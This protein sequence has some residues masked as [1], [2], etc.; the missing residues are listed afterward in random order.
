MAGAW[1]REQVPRAYRDLVRS[2]TPQVKR[3]LGTAL[4]EG[5]KWG[6]EEEAQRC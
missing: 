6:W 1:L 5:W 2:S 3:M 4:L